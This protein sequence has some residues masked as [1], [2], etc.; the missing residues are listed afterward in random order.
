MSK[1]CAQN[2]PGNSLRALSSLSQA[3]LGTGLG[4]TSVRVAMVLV[5]SMEF[6]CMANKYFISPPLPGFCLTISRFCLGD[7]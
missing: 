7:K 2:L 4:Q 5:K 6:Q 1:L 3:S